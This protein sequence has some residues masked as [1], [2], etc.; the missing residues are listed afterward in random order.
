LRQGGTTAAGRQIPDGTCLIPAGGSALMWLRPSSRS[1]FFFSPVGV[2][3]PGKGT[4][5]LYSD[6]QGYQGS[7]GFY[8]NE[9]AIQL[10]IIKP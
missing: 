10:T 5:P 3:I 8:S 9:N 1:D 4:A 7:V 6:A 2:S